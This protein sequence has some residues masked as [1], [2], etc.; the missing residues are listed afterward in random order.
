MNRLCTGDSVKLDV[1]STSLPRV[2]EVERKVGASLDLNMVVSSDDSGR[3]FDFVVMIS[4]AD[5]AISLGLV[6][7]VSATDGRRPPST[8]EARFIKDHDLFG[9]TTEV[10]AIDSGDTAGFVEVLVV[11]VV[12]GFF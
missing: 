12:S 8:F 1:G 10:W 6:A 4:V 2:A 7:N 9:S 3:G 11:A 5:D